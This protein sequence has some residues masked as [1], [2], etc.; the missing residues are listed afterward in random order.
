MSSA[1]RAPT[2]SK[3]CAARTRVPATFARDH[4]YKRHGMVTL[5]ANIDLLSG[6]VH[7]LVNDRHRSHEFV[8]FL[9]LIDPASPA[10]TAIK[11]ILDN[12]SAHISKE[13]KT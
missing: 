11:V 8:E 3:G 4:E 13:T 5:L 9:K 12:H 1:I 10:H 6:Q 7:A 2:L